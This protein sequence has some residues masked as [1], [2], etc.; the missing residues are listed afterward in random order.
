MEDGEGYRV[1]ISPGGTGGCLNG[2]E[3]AGKKV[4]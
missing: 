3:E 2:T 1:F 4:G